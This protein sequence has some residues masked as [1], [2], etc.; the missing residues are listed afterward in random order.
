MDQTE[1][2]LE[3]VAAKQLKPRAAIAAL[4]E[5][6][7]TDADAEEMVFITLGGSDRVSINDDGR[8]VYP[9]GRLVKDVERE[10]QA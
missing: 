5:L 7:H 6:G 1:D 3:R 8:A 4:L 10:M 2:I 9:S